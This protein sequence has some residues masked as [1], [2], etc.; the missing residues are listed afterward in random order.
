MS[1]RSELL[2]IIEGYKRQ[3]E[4][5]KSKVTKIENTMYLTEEG[6]ANEIEKIAIPFGEVAQNY[7]DRALETL[8]SGIE[9]LEKKWRDNSAGRLLDSNY[10]IGL[11]N[12]MK[13]I[14]AGAITN[15]EDFQNIINV[16]KDD[17]NAL[18][19]LRSLASKCEKVYGFS[20]LIPN[21]NREYNRK[22]LNDTKN[23]I[24][25]YINSFSIRDSLT[26]NLDGMIN[27]IK[28]RLKDDL[29]IIPWEEVK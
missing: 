23:N 19:M 13:M 7:Q 27:F 5:F 4:E 17:Y 10:Q 25:R 28:T 12:A 26:M 21:D 3:Q 9:A 14:E 15:K 8:D 24:E 11:T 1:K 6:K 29:T 20:I 18:A 16:Y 2:N 22:S